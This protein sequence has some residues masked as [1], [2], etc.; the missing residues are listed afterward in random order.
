MVKI[1]EAEIKKKKKEKSLHVK[2]DH[3]LGRYDKI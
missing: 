1:T 3:E 2:G